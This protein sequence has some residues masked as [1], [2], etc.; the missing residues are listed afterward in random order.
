MPDFI[1]HNVADWITGILLLAMVYLLAK[2]DSPAADFISAFSG[3][4]VALV[5]T[6]T[7]MPA[8][9]GGADSGGEEDSG[10]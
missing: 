6:A 2:P 7:D 1:R 3:A 9:D 4:M 8:G 5:K 10:D